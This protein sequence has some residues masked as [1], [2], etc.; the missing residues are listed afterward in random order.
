MS[1]R[2]R[3]D[4]PGEY[5]GSDGG[6]YRT[7]DGTPRALSPGE[8]ARLLRAEGLQP[9]RPGENERAAYDPLVNPD[10]ASIQVAPGF[11]P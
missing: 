2:P 5:G 3:Y 4:S 6:N 11:R 10:P 8:R 7:P 9:G 1:T